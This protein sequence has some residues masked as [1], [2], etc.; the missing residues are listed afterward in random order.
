MSYDGRP[1][2]YDCSSA[3]ADPLLK[4]LRAVHGC[5]RYDL[6]RQL[7]QAFDMRKLVRV[8]VQGVVTIDV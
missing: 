1:N 6:P 4:R 8:F 5:P 3:R 7:M 2:V